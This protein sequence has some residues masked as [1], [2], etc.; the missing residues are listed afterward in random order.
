MGNH[1][2]GDNQQALNS[3]TKNLGMLREQQDLHIV[4]W[5]QN[6]QDII[7]AYI[8]CKQNCTV[9]KEFYCENTK[10]NLM[11][12]GDSLYVFC[13][14]GEWKLIFASNFIFAGKNY[15]KQL[16]DRAHVVTAYSGVEQTMQYPTDR[17]QSQSLS[18]LLNSF[19]ASCDTYQRVKQSNKR[20]L[21]LVTPLHL[22]VRP[23]TGIWMDF[24]KLT[25]VFTLCSTIY[26]NI[27]IDNDHVACIQRIWT[28]VDCYSGYKFQIQITDYFK[29]D[30]ATRTYEVHVIPHIGYTNT[31]VFDRDSLFLSD[32]KHAYAASKG[33]LYE[34]STA[35]PQQTDG[36]TEIINDEV[37]T[38]VRACELEADQCVKKLPEIQL[39]LNSR[40]NSS[41]GSA[42]FDTLYGFTTRFG[43]AQMPYPGN[44]IVAERDRH[45]QVT[46]NLK[47]A[48][49]H[50]SF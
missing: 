45:A 12:I 40:Y 15:N 8:H 14:S 26:P 41:R 4:A 20:P 27:G 19:V 44:K 35:Y 28:I 36:Q 34:S 16:M 9:W 31:I 47:L 1:I 29:H 7:K 21:G 33:T 24:H 39:K 2:K 49:E 6:K 23:W 37:V 43:Q 25:P 11:K 46:N 3:V 18:A 38:I 50:Q 32:H 30:Q 10:P 5:M 48:K 17:Y 42:G 22:P 13:K